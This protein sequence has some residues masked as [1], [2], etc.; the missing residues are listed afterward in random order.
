MHFQRGKRKTI[1]DYKIQDIYKFYKKRCKEKGTNILDY[2]IF[3][4]LNKVFYENM[5]NR[6]IYE[7]AEF[8]IP[9]RLGG[10]RVKK[11]KQI[12]KLDEEGNVDKR[13][14]TPNWKKTKEYW[15]RIY[16]DKTAEEIKEIKDKHIVYE[17]NEHTDGY[18]FSFFWDK[19]TCVIPNQSAYYFTPI[20][21]YKERLNV[22]LKTIKNLQYYE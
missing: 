21:K 4:R 1:A 18:R 13:N 14:L 16:E 8:T 22:A 11:K 7:G 20:R 15:A 12:L 3:V 5:M 2:T 9:Y 6:I 19:I 17:L 10:L